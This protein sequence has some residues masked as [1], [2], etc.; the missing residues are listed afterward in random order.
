MLDLVEQLVAVL[1]IERRKASDHFKYNGAQAPP[2]DWFAM[3]FLE[4]NF[5]GEVLRGSADGHCVIVL[6][7]HLR[8]S[9][10]SES[11][12]ACLIDQDVLRFETALLNGVLSVD[13]VLIMQVLQGQHNLCSVKLSLLLRKLGLL[14]Q[15]TK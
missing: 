8:K 12:V 5:G 14:G 2:V 6:H 3:S 13:D 10:V 1:A 7:F 4:N 15:K 11:Q 9:E